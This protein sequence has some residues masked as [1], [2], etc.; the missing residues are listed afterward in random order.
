M[1]RNAFGWRAR[2]VVLGGLVLAGYPLISQLEARQGPG[3]PPAAPRPTINLPTDPMLQGFRWRS[4]GPVGQGARIDDF[5]VDE[6][7]PS[8]Y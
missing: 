2:A 8:T 4:I 6:R 7:N 5:A 1:R 3:G